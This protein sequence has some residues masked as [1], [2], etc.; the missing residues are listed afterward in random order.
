MDGRDARRRARRYYEAIDEARYEDLRTLLDAEFVHDR[1]DRTLRGRDRFVEFMREDRPRT[2]TSHAIDDVYANGD[3][4][5]VHGR[6]LAA[7]GEPLFA[8]VDVF[9]TA[10]N[11][12]GFASLRTYTR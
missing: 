2:D 8:F 7:S 3:D 5:A 9:E 10:E 11:G 1:P 6:L 12:R 4:V